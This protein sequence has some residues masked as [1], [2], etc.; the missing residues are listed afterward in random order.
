MVSLTW[1]VWP[2]QSD[3]DSLTWSVWPGQS[4][5]V[6]LRKKMELYDLIHGAPSDFH[7]IN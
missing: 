1:S 2:G 6:N 7:E 4:D 5:L 3:L